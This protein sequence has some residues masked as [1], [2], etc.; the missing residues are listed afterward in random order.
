ML[1]KPTIDT[2]MNTEQEN[3]TTYWSHICQ[4]FGWKMFDLALSITVCLVFLD[5]LGR[6]YCFRH[7]TTLYHGL[8]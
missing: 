1:H 8:R 3:Q 5:D 2:D 7:K 6:L 4:N